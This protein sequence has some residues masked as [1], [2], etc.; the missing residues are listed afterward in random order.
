MTR[1]SGPV[2]RPS[3]PVTRPSG[4]VTRPARPVTRPA[5]PVEGPTPGPRP[6]ADRCRT[7]IPAS[8]SVDI[9]GYSPVSSTS[10]SRPWDAR[11][12]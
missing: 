10:G 1:P 5:R 9:A 3:G 4:P 7:P 11:P 6:Y 8:S 12:Q 2:T